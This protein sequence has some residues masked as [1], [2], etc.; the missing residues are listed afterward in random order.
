MTRKKNDDVEA[1]TTEAPA[2][3][4]TEAAAQ[5]PVTVDDAVGENTEWSAMHKQIKRDPE[6]D[7]PILPTD[8]DSAVGQI[9][10]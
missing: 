5:T 3:D 8:T 10:K 1:E 2:A 4:T 6:D 7:S 9:V